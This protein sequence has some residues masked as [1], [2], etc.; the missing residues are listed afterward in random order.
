[1]Y[2]GVP[3]P[4]ALMPKDP[5][6][7]PAPAPVAA[8]PEP[9]PAPA[10]DTDALLRKAQQAYMSNYYGVAIE[11]AREVLKTKPN[12]LAAYQ[13]IAA[14]SCSLGEAAEAREAAS[15]LDGKRR[16]LALSVCE[17]KGIKIDE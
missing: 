1:M 17:R 7:A 13:I 8:T 10:V 14:C 11:N 5:E 4:A 6:P 2:G 16:K 15:H 3:V 12:N 9:P